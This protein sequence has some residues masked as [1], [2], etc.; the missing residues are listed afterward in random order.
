LND[1]FGDSL[2]ISS[3]GTT[4]VVGAPFENSGDST[5]QEDDTSPYAGAV[6]LY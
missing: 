3:D 2:S 4:L 1:E 5:N 6:Y